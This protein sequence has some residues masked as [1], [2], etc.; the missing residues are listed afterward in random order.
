ML[1][2]I[3]RGQRNEACPEPG[4][5]KFTTHDLRNAFATRALPL[6]ETLPVIGN[7]HGHADSETTARY[8]IS[9]VAPSARLPT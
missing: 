4:P 9:S 6:G 5:P 3:G 1:G 2:W 8:P 7:L